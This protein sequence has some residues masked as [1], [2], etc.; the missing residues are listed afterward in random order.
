[1]GRFGDGGGRG[2]ARLGGGRCLS[3]VASRLALNGKSKVVTECPRRAFCSNV[4]SSAV[5]MKF[6]I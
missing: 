2:G 1:M 3:N 5:V 4:A 6:G